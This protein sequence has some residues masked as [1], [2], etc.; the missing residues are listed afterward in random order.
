M[1]MDA[2]MSH[3]CFEHCKALKSLQLCMLHECD[4]T[5][6]HN[7][8]LAGPSSVGRCA[9]RRDIPCTLGASHR[10]LFCMCRTYRVFCSSD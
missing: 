5:N 1:T 9:Y 3:W 10:N 4:E 2:S 6:Q 7:C 8:Q